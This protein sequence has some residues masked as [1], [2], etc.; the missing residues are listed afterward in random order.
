M[1]FY[2]GS[3]LFRHGFN[4]T[5]PGVLEVVAELVP[6]H[7]DV[8]GKDLFFSRLGFEPKVHHHFL[9]AKGTQSHPCLYHTVS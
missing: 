4:L 2:K 9:K 6:E 8:V 3:P 5:V 7:E 1:D